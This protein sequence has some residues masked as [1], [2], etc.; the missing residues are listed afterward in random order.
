MNYNPVASLIARV[1]R[2]PNERINVLT[3]IT[4]SPFETELSRCNVNLYGM[5]EKNFLGW[6]YCRPVP[7][8]Y[9]I[10]PKEQGDNAIP[11]NVDFHCVLSQNPDVHYPVLAR[12]AQMFQVPIISLYHTT[13]P[14]AMSNWR[15]YVAYAKQTYRSH[16][17]VFI[18]ETSREQ[19]DHVEDGIVIHHSAD[20]KNFTP[21]NE[22]RQPFV[23]YTC[24]ALRE[25]DWCCGN[26]LW[27]T[28]S[29]KFPKLLVGNDPDPN[30]SKPINDPKE[31][32]IVLN[33]CGV[34]LNCSLQSPFPMSLLE[35]ATAGTPIVTTAT[36]EIPYVFEHRKSAMLFNPEQPDVGE[37]Y[38]RQLLNDKDMAKELGE[39]ARKAVLEFFNPQKFT[40]SWTK[41]FEGVS[42]L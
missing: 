36:C 14:T 28:I 26:T 27:E 7:P 19:W 3:G 33:K 15:Q 39:N 35:A 20:V 4:H 13:P 8:N 16:A 24:N 25:R 38:V 23:M 29:S 30:Y 9:Y 18:S 11:S 10:L 12:Y 5:Q 37:K 41:V 31:L 17:N 21:L 1:V 6:N 42:R 22:E 32:N 40:D 34:Y 2:K